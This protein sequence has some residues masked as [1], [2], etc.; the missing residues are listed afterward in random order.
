MKQHVISTHLPNIQYPQIGVE[1]CA[2]SVRLDGYID[3]IVE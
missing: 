1:E 2:P 3:A